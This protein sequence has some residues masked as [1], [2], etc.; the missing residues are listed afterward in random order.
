MSLNHCFITNEEE[1][2]VLARF[3]EL[4][5]RS[6]QLDCLVGFFY[7]SG[8]YRVREALENADTVR[9]LIG[10]G[11]DKETFRA[12]DQVAKSHKQAKD[13]VFDMVSND[14][15]DS[16]DKE[17][18]EEGFEKFVDWHRNGKLEIRAH[19]SKTLH[20]KIY[21]YSLRDDVDE[22][23][24]ITGSSNFTRG[25]LESNFEINAEFRNPPEYHFAKEKFQKLWEES[26]EVTE[27]YVKSAEGSWLKPIAP[28][29]LYLK[30]LYEYFRKELGLVDKVFDTELPEGFLDLKYQQD[31]VLEAKRAL[32]KHGGVF[33]S[34]VV[35]LGKTYIAAILAKELAGKTIVIA[36]PV[37]LEESNPGSWNNVFFFLGGR[38]AKFFSIG[39]LDDVLDKL[40]HENYD[41]VIIDEA[42][43]FRNETNMTYEKMA[44]I[45]R[46][47][48]VI[49]V[50]AT[51]YNN[52]PSDLLNQI[53]LFQNPKKSTVGIPDLDR[54]FKKLELSLRGLDRQKDREKYFETTRR[55]AAEI[56]DKVLRDIMIRRTR[57]DIEKVYGED[58]KK[59]GIEF[60]EVHNPISL[61]YQFNEEE[62]QIF[63]QTIKL[64][65][66]PFKYSR[67][68]PL[69]EL[70]PEHRIGQLQRQAQVNLG[71]FMKILL[72]KRL[73]SSFHAFR[74]TI[75]R[76]IESYQLFIR[77]LRNGRVLTSKDYSNKLFN[78]LGRDDFDKIQD[79]IDAGDVEVYPADNFKD[80][81]MT[82]LE[83]DLEILLRIQKMWKG[84]QR[85]PKLLKFREE[86]KKRKELKSK[87]VLF[88]ESKETA[89]YLADNIKDIEPK[90]LC[91]SG[92]SDAQ[93]RE[94][95][96]DNFDDKARN[97]KDDYRVL[98]STEVLSEGVNLHRSNVVI[99]YDIPW[100][101]TR[102]MQRVGRV[103][104]IDTKHKEIYTFNF[105]P[106][107]QSNELIKLEEAAEAKIE[108]FLTLLGDDASLLTEN[109]PIG[110]HELFQKLKSKKTIT[111]EEEEGQSEL[112]YFKVIKDVRDKNVDLFDR[113]KKLPRKARS[114]KL[115]DKSPGNLISF[116][117]KG[118]VDR[119]YKAGKDGKPEDITFLES[120]ELLS[121]DPDERLVSMPRNYFHLLEANKDAFEIDTAEDTKEAGGGGRDSARDVIKT[122]K[123]ALEDTRSL[124]EEQE[125]YLEDVLEKIYTLPKHTISEVRKKFQKLGADVMDSLKVVSILKHE[126]TD[127]LLY[128][129]YAEK[130]AKEKGQHEIILSMFLKG[131]E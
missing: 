59:Q 42:H 30:F 109:E 41:N 99:N 2:T 54:F 127:E 121:T 48:R 110:S 126:L 51:P 14:L 31:A 50:S 122:I 17:E 101:P 32:E 113:I 1:R 128:P 95:V 77:E 6:K 82:N 44:R 27:E 33:L 38:S 8:F 85:D 130:K 93:T 129:H 23:H 83:E 76:F 47:K 117:R 24:V 29:D 115:S 35:G 28:Y 131:D 57:R 18:V 123:L 104:R 36:P 84:V 73:E 119:F 62:D 71:G 56:R 89:E 92:N 21:I 124:T 72:V 80:S 63:Y 60:P 22:G 98:I 64:I 96:L 69:L 116:F 106:T 34:D 25:G 55:N 79:M 45:C 65:T 103:N 9:I 112:D 111:G 26:V 3:I 43:R 16:E 86:L 37:L 75:D 7:L 100:N 108:A 78:L 107:T 118:D 91:F 15:A 49:L 81:L 20:A 46:G 120:A 74:M 12:I 114:S 68:M 4:V 88:T 61:Y 125:S 70:K 87:I 66:G 67:Y 53:K 90:T 102:M 40:G 19:P 11:T 97:R 52:R 58:L 94:D 105:F 13:T 39:K 10:M 5:K